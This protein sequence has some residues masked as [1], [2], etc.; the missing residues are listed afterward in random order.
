[1]DNLERGRGAVSIGP[2][3][4][5]D[6]RNEPKHMVSEDIAAEI[7]NLEMPWLALRTSGVSVGGP[8]D[9]MIRRIKDLETELER[10]E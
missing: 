8:D 1:M 3:A 9:W 2:D 4:L 7:E 6:W 5:A 10:R